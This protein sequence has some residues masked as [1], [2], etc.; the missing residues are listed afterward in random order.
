MTVFN[1]YANGGRLYSGIIA[2]EDAPHFLRGNCSESPA[3][4]SQFQLAFEVPSYPE[5]EDFA[6][7]E[8][9]FI[10]WWDQL[11]C[12]FIVDEVLVCFDFI[13]HTVKHLDVEDHVHMLRK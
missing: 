8:F 11:L 2:L 9:N 7:R 1:D 3:S 13:L 5:V 10:S 4:S 6:I 12:S